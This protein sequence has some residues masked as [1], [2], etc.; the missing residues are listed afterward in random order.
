MKGVDGFCLVFRYLKR[1][2]MTN[3]FILGKIFLHGTEN[4]S[5]F[6]PVPHIANKEEKTE[7]H[8]ESA[9]SNAKVFVPFTRFSHLFSKE[10]SE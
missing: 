6:Y 3:R 2:T 4:I 7:A 1:E 5:L 10:H 9:S 8:I